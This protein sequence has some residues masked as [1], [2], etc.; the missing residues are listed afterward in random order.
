M[1]AAKYEEKLWITIS[2]RYTFVYLNKLNVSY[3][4]TVI[5][6]MSS[7]LNILNANCRQ[8]LKTNFTMADKYGNVSWSWNYL[9]MNCSRLRNRVACFSL[10]F[11]HL[12]FLSLWILPNIYLQYKDIIVVA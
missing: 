5:I 12:V 4:I 9:L 7:L 10:F 8:P 11:F 6:I 3:D 1:Y 2:L